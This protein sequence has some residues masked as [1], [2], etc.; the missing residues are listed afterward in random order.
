[1]PK[2]GPILPEGA[3][4]FQTFAPKVRAM[5]PARSLDRVLL[6]LAAASILAL[7]AAASFR[8]VWEADFF[9]QW[10]TGEL[11]ART[12][13]PRVDTLSETSR[14]RPW[15]EMR[16]L[17]CRLLHAVV[18][19]AGFSGAVV[20]KALA[21]LAAFGL[22]LAASPWRRSAVAACLV[23]PVA[24][25]A[26]SQRFYVRPELASFLFFS[27]FV[28]LCVRSR[29]GSHGLLYA[30]PP[31]Q[32]L[33][34]NLHTLFL[35]GPAVAG[36]FVGLEAIRLRGE[37]RRLLRPAAVLVATCAACFVTPYGMAGVRFGVRLLSEL[38]D[39]VY[40]RMAAEFLPTFHFGQRYL[41]VVFFEVLIGLCTL[42]AVGRLRRLDPFLSLL[43]LA[44]LALALLSIRNLPLFCLAAVPFAV[45]HAPADAAWPAVLRRGTLVG[46][47]VL[48][49]AASWA[50]ATDR[51][52][53][54]Q[55]DTN[56]F[57]AGLAA[58]RFPVGATRYVKERLRPHRLFHP[59]FEGSYLVAEG[60][61]SF[62]DPRLEVQGSAHLA[63]Y[64]GMMEDPAA[65]REAM[66]R[67][68]F[69]AAL[70]DLG[71][72]FLRHL[73]DGNAWSLVYFDAEDAV[74]VPAGTAP[75]MTDAEI[76]ARAAG[77]QKSLGTPLPYAK[78]G[79]LDRVASPAPYLRT[80]RFL[81]QLGRP[82]EAEPFAAAAL[83]AYP[84]VYG[85]HEIL[86]RA[87]E[88]RDALVPALAEYQAERTRDPANVL[89]ARQAGI[90][91]FRLG[92]GEEALPLLTEAVQ[93]VPADA[94]VWG[95]LTKI[96]AD[97][98]RMGPALTCAR[99]AAALVPGS[100]SY[101]TNLGKLSAVAGRVEDG[102][103]ALRHA[104]ALAP[105]QADLHRDL[106]VL[107]E[108][109]GRREEAKAEAERAQ[110]MQQEAPR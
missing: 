17:Y 50:L 49:L 76:D 71:S 68:R 60:V 15:I 27:L 51:F 44:Q 18:S 56:Q 101:Q 5:P 16:W 20:A 107:L 100:V 85:A 42:A 69:D 39:P 59:M 67:F 3:L 33:W 109:A 95:V 7:L 41:A 57:G 96:H 28:C 108:R 2:T 43:T 52:Y 66:E 8:R 11:V 94:E 80:A 31:L 35:L 25:L 70:V 29:K 9:W 106:A 19:A 45:T 24:I 83:T 97:A 82:E 89:A 62:V 14:G 30:L 1:M 65:W 4:T 48:A 12:G 47:T 26:A 103:E 110:R 73:L 88:A 74:F 79:M 81:V 75:A 64:A 55:H 46:S 104:V 34:A 23:L 37:P 98:G 53:V 93:R 78:A 86:G 87:A 6:A 36:L 84:K 61:P 72:P 90:L 40:Q 77:L 102:I 32:V 63:R 22:A 99:Q 58:H 21:V 105:G 92:R 38:R 10:K 91:A 54:W 13:P